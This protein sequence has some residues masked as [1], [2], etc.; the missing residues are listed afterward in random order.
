M[1]LQGTETFEILKEIGLNIGLLFQITDDL[2]DF[3]G[4]R[5]IVGKPTK[6]DKNKGKPTLVNLLGYEK[7]LSFAHNLK[8]K[9]SKKIKKYGIKSG[10]LLGEG[11]AGKVLKC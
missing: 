6:K 1:Q 10:D 2:I 8:K 4:N 9:L 11:A 3:K 5:K 7:T